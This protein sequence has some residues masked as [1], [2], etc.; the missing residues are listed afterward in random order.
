[1]AISEV[2]TISNDR[3]IVTKHRLRII[4]PIEKVN[5][6]SLSRS[7]AEL[8]NDALLAKLSLAIILV[9]KCNLGTSDIK[10]IGRR[11]SRYPYPRYPLCTRSRHNLLGNR[12]LF[13]V[14]FPEEKEEKEH[15]GTLEPYK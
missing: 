8:G 12:K 10:Y 4:S 1:M 2:T 14:G 3:A 13:L 6:Y 5:R 15:Q 11:I 9:S 7:Q